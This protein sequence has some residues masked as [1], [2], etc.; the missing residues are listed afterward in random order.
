MEGLDKYAEE[1][2]GPAS[3]LGK[4][5]VG[6]LLQDQFDMK[7]VWSRNKLQSLSDDVRLISNDFH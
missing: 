3:Y 5:P 6:N 2:F 4:S 1:A 7:A